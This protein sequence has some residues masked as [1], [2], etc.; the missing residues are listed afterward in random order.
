MPPN[1]GL[2]SA[3]K[4]VVIVAKDKLPPPS[5]FKNCPAEPSEVGC[6]NPSRITLPEPLGVI[7]ILPLDADTIDWPL[8]SKSPP[9]WGVV[10]CARE[11]IPPDVIETQAEPL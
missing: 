6:D 1:C 9:S 8:T 11:V 3:D 10:S 2:V 4:S 7:D 5:V